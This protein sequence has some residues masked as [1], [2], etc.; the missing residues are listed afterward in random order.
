M[1]KAIIF[2]LDDT[3]YPELEYV[4][5]GFRAIAGRLAGSEGD[6]DEVYEMLWA[7]FEEGPRDRVFNRVLRR[8]GQ[9]DDRQVIAELV[10]Q[11]R[12]HRPCLRLDDGVREL[13]ERLRGR[14]KLGLISDGYMPGQRLKVEALGLEGFFDRIIYTEELGRAYWKPAT[15]A[16]ELMAEAL[17]VEPGECVYVADNPAKDFAGPNGLGWQTV[18]VKRADGVHDGRVEDLAEGYAAKIVVEDLGELE[19]VLA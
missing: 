3:L 9:E 2:D 17:G 12:C 10:G 14:Y 18:Q 4:K 11:Y 5:S 8:L 1:I 7:A 16:F 6:A 15:R 13:L 19:G